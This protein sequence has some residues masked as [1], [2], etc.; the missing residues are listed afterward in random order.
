MPLEMK[1]QAPAAGAELEQGWHARARPGLEPA[2]QVLGFLDVV[3]RWREQGPPMGELV[4]EPGAGRGHFRLVRF[5]LALRFGFARAFGWTRS[6]SLA[7]PVSRF[8][9]SKVSGEIF[10]LTSSSANFLRC[11]L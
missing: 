1:G 10:P 8:H 2:N 9:S 4:V 7:P 3:L 5:A 11:A 6:G